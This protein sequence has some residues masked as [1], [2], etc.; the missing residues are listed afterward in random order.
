MRP[1]ER[2]HTSGGGDEHSHDYE[3]TN[4]WTVLEVYSS[5][6]DGPQ[7]DCNTACNSKEDDTGKQWSFKRTGF[8]EDHWKAGQGTAV[9]VSEISWSYLH[10]E[11]NLHWKLPMEIY[12]YGTMDPWSLEEYWYE[13][14]LFCKDWSLYGKHWHNY[15]KCYTSVIVVINC[16]WTVQGRPKMLTNNLP[17]MK[18]IGSTLMVE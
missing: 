10:A 4:L 5:C 8:F 18:I 6:K 11:L 9:S 1:I 17:M 13:E 3:K 7:K 14:F 12:I 15:I 2:T 16:L